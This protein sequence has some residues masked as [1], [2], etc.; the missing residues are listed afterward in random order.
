ML[1]LLPYSLLGL[2][3]FFE[4]R[5]DAT[6][7]SARRT[8][9][10]SS[11]RH[12]GEYQGK[13]KGRGALRTV[14]TSRAARARRRSSPPL[15]GG[16]TCPRA[17]RFRRRHRPPATCPSRGRRS[18]RCPCARLWR[19]TRAPPRRRLRRRAPHRCPRGR[20]PR[21]RLPPPRAPLP[22][23]ASPGPVVPRR[24]P[25]RPCG[26]GA[27]RTA[28]RGRSPRALAQRRP[29]QRP[30]R[31]PACGPRTCPPPTSLPAPRAYSQ[32]LLVGSS[33]LPPPVVVL[34]GEC[35][36]RLRFSGRLAGSYVHQATKLPS[37]VHKTVAQYRTGTMH[38]LE[39][40]LP[41]THFLGTW[42]N[43]GKRKAG[44][45]STPA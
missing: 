10:N 25:P 13:K 16:P 7:R 22:A 39:Y 3:N 1:L 4:R 41:R 36:G 23:A 33:V 17:P 31:N 18:H 2:A 9:E 21:P 6:V 32:R 12:L 26:H 43:R 38:D 11:S 19:G 20:P 24:S 42:V 45:L 14:A 27:E 8:S 15:A 40:G 5:H 30:S 44:V 35:T 34:R 37:P 28:Y 29:S